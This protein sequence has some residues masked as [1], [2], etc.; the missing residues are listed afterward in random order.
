MSERRVPQ[1]VAKPDRLDQVLV[2]EERPADGAGDLGYLEGMGETGPVVVRGGSDKDLGLVHQPTKALAV[3]NPVSV[4]LERRSQVAFRLRR[5]SLRSAAGPTGWG[6]KP[7][8]ALFQ[9]LSNGRRRRSHRSSGPFHSI[10][11]ECTS[12]L[13]GRERP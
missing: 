10:R 3:E 8:L 13:G 1:I 5:G 6:E 2:E 12:P 9:K 4:P 7:L 11:A